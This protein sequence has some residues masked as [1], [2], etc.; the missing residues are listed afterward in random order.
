[1]TERQAE[2]ATGFNER[3]PVAPIA[4]RRRRNLVVMTRRSRNARHR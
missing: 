4:R 1:M 3:D 2:R